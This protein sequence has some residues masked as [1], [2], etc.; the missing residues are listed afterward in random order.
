MPFLIVYILFFSF[1]GSMAHALD[2]G[3]LVTGTTDQ[4]EKHKVT[5]GTSILGWGL[6]DRITVGTSPIM[7]VG[8]DLFSILSRVS[9]YQN[10]RYQIAGDFF[11]FVSDSSKKTQSDF[12]QESWYLRLN[13]TFSINPSFR[14]HTSVG[15]QYFINEVSTYSL[16]SDPLGRWST[17][18]SKLSDTHDDKVRDYSLNPRD[19]K[20][21][22]LSLM[23]SFRFTERLTFNFE[24]GYL[25]TNYEQAFVHYGLSLSY[26][27]HKLDM[28]W[29]TSRSS[30]NILTGREVLN[31]FESKL[32]YYF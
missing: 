22:S 29:G 13:Q 17:F 2:W 27:W 25:G 15:L 28:T 32:Q 19:P 4:L 30:R 31:H 21:I 18:E 8:Y 6:S 16:R 9:V 1:F 26:R 23:P 24:Y 10:E 14:L 3:H 11:Y 12:E 5:A 7:Y 20:T